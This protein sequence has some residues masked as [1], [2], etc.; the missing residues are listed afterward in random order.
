[1]P[2]GMGHRLSVAVGH[3]RDRHKELL[4]EQRRRGDGE[5]VADDASHIHGQVDAGPGAAAS[6]VP[7]FVEVLA[8]VEGE[9][10]PMTAAVD[11]E[12]GWEHQGCEAVVVLDV[13]RDRW[14]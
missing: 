6:L 11:L 12:R 5:K 14:W 9:L 13:S 3:L 8:G 10:Q 7:P 1:M 4:F 2:H